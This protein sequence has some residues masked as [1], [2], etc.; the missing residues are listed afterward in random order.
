MFSSLSLPESIG[1]MGVE[2]LNEKMDTAE[3]SKT[4]GYLSPLRFASL[5]PQGDCYPHFIRSLLDSLS[6]QD[7]LQ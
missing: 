1:E 6:G 5:G 7:L 4:C 3:P 2:G